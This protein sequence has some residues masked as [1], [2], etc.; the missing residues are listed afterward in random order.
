MRGSIEGFSI[1]VVEPVEENI[2]FGILN[3]IRIDRSD[4]VIVEFEPLST[5]IVQGV[6][7]VMS[8]AGSTVMND[9]RE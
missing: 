6:G 5:Q 9:T 4:D 7:D 2:S 1:V 3:D 8:T